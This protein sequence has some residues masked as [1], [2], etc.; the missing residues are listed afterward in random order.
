MGLPQNPEVHCLAEGGEEPR[1]QGNL[2][3]RRLGQLV[4]GDEPGQAA[5]LELGAD[6]APHRPVGHAGEAVTVLAVSVPADLAFSRRVRGDAAQDVSPVRGQEL[7]AREPAPAGNEVGPRVGHLRLGRLRVVESRD[8]PVEFHQVGQ[9]VPEDARVREEVAEV[10]RPFL[11]IA[12]V[13]AELIDADIEVEAAEHPLHPL[14][15][16]VGVAVELVLAH[17]VVLEVDHAA[18]L[19]RREVETQEDRVVPEADEDLDLIP[20]GEDFEVGRLGLS[21]DEAAM[22]SSPRR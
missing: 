10:E 4:P 8:H 2:R 15:R 11:V 14:K 18:A 21:V 17:A 5:G 19:G 16:D 6:P 13:E 12:D 1:L 9:E 7:R 3:D 20:V 22:P